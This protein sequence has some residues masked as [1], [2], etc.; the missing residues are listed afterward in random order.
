M[1][2]YHDAKTRA[3]H[4]SPVRNNWYYYFMDYHRRTIRLKQYDY[5]ENGYYFVTICTQNRIN[6]FGEIE[7]N[8]MVLNKNGLILKIW[9]LNLSNRFDM[10]IDEYQ[11]MPNHIHLII[12]IV[13]ANHDSPKTNDEPGNRAIRES[14]IRA[15]RESPLQKKRSELSKIIGYL[16]M[17]V[18]KE[19]GLKIWQ[20]NYYERII[21]NEKEYLKIKEYIKSNPTMWGRDRNNPN[22]TPL[23]HRINRCRVF[24]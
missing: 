5:S 3:I 4:K 6:I 15:I 18:S 19:I 22:K 20:R 21:R 24:R 9:L 16:K 13:G 1:M 12:R 2:A 7:N 10:T 8:Q 17:N 11:I 23:L 14:N